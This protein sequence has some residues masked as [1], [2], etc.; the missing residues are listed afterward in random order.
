MEPTE[1]WTAQSASDLYDVA[2]WGKGY[3]SVGENG[4]VR[5]H[6]EK[7]PARFID[8]KQ[9]ID[10]LVLRGINLPIL[11]RFADILK[12][13]LGELHTAFQTAINDHKYQG[14]YC[15]VYPI[16]VNQQRQVVEEVLE[17]GRPYQ[18]GLEAGSKPELM[19][20]MAMADNDTPIICNGFKDD[21][22]IEMAM[23]AQKVGR[24]IIP[25]VEKYTEL[26][27]IQ[28]YSQRV[29][30]RPR[31]GLR[32]KL[33]SRGSGRWKSS[34]GYRSKFGLSAT[35]AMRALQELKD[36]GMADCINL[37]HFHLGS[38]ITN[39]R[40]I[41]GAVNE[42]VRVYV[43]LARAGAGLQYLDVGGGLGIDYDGSQTDFESS[44]NYTLQEY[45]NDVIYHVQNVCDEVGVAHPT[46]VS[47]SGRAVVAYHSL[48][49]F[50]VLGVSNFDQY[51]LPPAVPP[52]APQQVS[53]LFAIHRDLKKKNL[54]ESYHDAVQAVDEALNM[55]NLGG[56][57]I[58]MRALA[59]RLFWA[60]CIKILK[61]VRELDYTPE[62]LQGL[63]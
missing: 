5:V 21:E 27:L 37:L 26:H 55:F 6:P 1:R 47:E 59:E 29:G 56:L 35:E 51:Q 61:M 36:L 28:K 8:L 40:Q 45:A 19:A 39:I 16:K 33:A 11:I 13:R 3:F 50:D 42:A 14:K 49:V 24:H 23:L 38:Q 9:L 4:H 25:G 43:D 54:L 34:G 48:L 52:E 15:C 17:F 10:T 60:V 12:H 44:V 30:V 22:Y 62:E 20:V 18:F 32:V 31:I 57:D 53:D 58:E 41:K 46:I 63:E 2:S 7:D